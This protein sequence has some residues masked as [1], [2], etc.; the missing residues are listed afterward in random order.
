MVDHYAAALGLAYGL[1]P[2]DIDDLRQEGQLAALEALAGWDEAKGTLSTYL[3]PRVSGAMMSWLAKEGK[4]GLTGVGKF[5]LESF[6]NIDGDYHGREDANYESDMGPRGPCEHMA[7]EEVIDYLPSEDTQEEALINQ[8]LE[9]VDRMPTQHRALLAEYYG[10]N[11]H[12]PLTLRELAAKRRVTL[13]V[14]RRR[15]DI[16]LREANKILLD[17]GVRV[18]DV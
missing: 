9:I 6:V 12:K 15:V 7:T 11:G 18:H 14:M 5:T 2:S 17:R 8:V 1:Q 4:R 13:A 16:A 10:L 3:I